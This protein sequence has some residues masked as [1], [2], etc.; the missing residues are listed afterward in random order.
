MYIKNKKKRMRYSKKEID[1]VTL[2][3]VTV[4]TYTQILLEMSTL[5]YIIEVTTIII[6][7]A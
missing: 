6:P 1:V 3:A 5:C 2:Q 7:Y 4:T